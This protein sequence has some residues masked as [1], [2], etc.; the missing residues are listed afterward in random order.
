MITMHM[1]KFFIKQLN[2]EIIT[3]NLTAVRPVSYL[4]QAKYV[5][6]NSLVEIFSGIKFTWLKWSQLLVP[7][8]ST[9]PSGIH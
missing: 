7:S 9:S 6:E 1:D 2:H 4:E 3:A 8:S 5:C